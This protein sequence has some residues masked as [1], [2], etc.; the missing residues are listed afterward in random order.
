MKS[1]CRDCLATGEAKA[2]RCPSC[3]SPR[4][5]F[6]EELGTLSMAHLD[7]DAFYASV[8]KRDD[9]SL[10]DKPVIV[11]GGKRGV[12]TTACYIAR[13]S[14]PRSAMPMYKALKLCPEAVVIKPNFAKYKHESRRIMASSRLTPLVQPLSL[15]EAWI[16]LTGTERLHGA[17]P[18]VMLARLQAEIEREVGL[19]VSIGLAPNKFL[20][21]IASELDKPRGFSVIG[22]AG[23]VDL[24]G[25]QAGQHPARRRAGH[26][27]VPGRDRPEDRRRHRRRRPEDGWSRAGLGRSAAASPGSRPATA[28]WSIPTRSA[29]RSA[30][31]PPSTTTCYKREDLEDELWPLC[32]KVAKQARAG[33]RGRPGG[34]AEAAHAG[35]QDPHPPPHPGR[36]DPDGPH[37]VPGGARAAGGRATRL[38]TTA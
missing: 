18:A 26:R 21:K 33:R 8:E 2:A 12:V 10:R 19:T 29:R 20:A 38:F 34:D 7:C 32:E 1:L 6:H 27:G 11:G 5:I 22:S 3:G 36:A 28:G 16:D 35:L 9:P 13:M 15:D 30:P 17:T 4:T 37:P 31:R 25:Q 14:G 23:P 24:P